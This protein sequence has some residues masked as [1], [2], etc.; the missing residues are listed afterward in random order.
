VVVRDIFSV[1]L[2][3]WLWM[4]PYYGANI[5]PVSDPTIQ[6]NPEFFLKVYPKSG[7]STECR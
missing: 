6:F 4:V 7:E 3:S 1:A 2:A 5:V